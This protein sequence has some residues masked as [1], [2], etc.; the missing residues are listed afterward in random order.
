MSLTFTDPQIKDLTQGVLDAPNE[1]AKANI[2]KAAAIT[3]QA[4][5]L[6]QDNQNAVYTANWNN[7]ITQY[8]AEVKY[9]G[10]TAYTDY[11]LANVPIAG[12]LLDGIHFPKSP[13]WTK[14]QPKLDASNN[15][16]PTSVWAQTESEAINRATP[17]IT[18]LKTGFTSGAASTTTTGA[19][20][21]LTGFPLTSA[22]GISPGHTI[23]FI[24]GSNYLYGTVLTVAGLDVDVTIISASAGTA[25]ILSGATAKNFHPGFTLGQR[26]SGVGANPGESAYMASIKTLID[27]AVADWKTRL[28]AEKSALLLNDA[29][30]TEATQITAAKSQVDGHI[31][32]ITTWQAFPSIGVGTSRFGTNL[33]PLEADLAL[34]PSEY[35]TRISQ[36]TTALGSATQNPDGTYAGTGN[37]FN[38][39]DNLNLRLNLAGG[40]LRTY[41]DSALGVTLFDQQITNLTNTMNRDLATFDIHI[42]S[43]DATGT[44]TI[45]LASVTGLAPAQSVKVMSKTQAVITANIVSISAP[46]VVLDQIIP[47]TYKV[48]ESGRL[49]RQL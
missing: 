13:M 42:F 18:L 29:T 8:H 36:I 48:S 4:K 30:G 31:T 25:G 3:N 24:S 5:V 20:V 12:Q 15:G 47:N 22:A 40:T 23:L 16:N 17:N 7:I 35:A 10:G 43:F 46:N 14:F 39:F 45:K 6:A 19:Y 27:T 2:A 21:P 28:N 26:E 44:T 32:V 1:I 34:R 37:Y 9:L 41:Y 33:P 49:V 11:N 38:L